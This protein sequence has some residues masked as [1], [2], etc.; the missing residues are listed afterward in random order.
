[1]I[2]IS[3]FV[4]GRFSG[5]AEEVVALPPNFDEKEYLRAHPDVALAVR[6]KQFKSG[7]DHWYRH[8]RFE[9]R[10][11][12][13]SA[14]QVAPPKDLK[15][16]NDWRR[17]ADRAGDSAAME[18]DGGER[19]L[20]PP[21]FD[22][23]EYLRCHPDV[24][25]AIAAKHFDSGVQHWLK[26]GRF[27]GRRWTPGLPR[28]RMASAA[29]KA[30][31]EAVLSPPRAGGE[32]LSEGFEWHAYAK[33]NPDVQVCFGMSRRAFVQGSGSQIGRGIIGRPRA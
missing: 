1:M 32:S 4:R 18:G 20:L 16:A 23:A 8:G 24:Q 29:S 21:D 11:L 25:A 15:D 19:H 13:A 12:R 9:D 33:T 17:E 3:S 30:R 14:G 6:R 5:K 31:A 7:A 26:K 28:T 22:E 10:R 2:A 27:E